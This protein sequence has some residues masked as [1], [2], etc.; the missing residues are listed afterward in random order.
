LTQYFLIPALL[1]PWPTTSTGLPKTVATTGGS[2]VIDELVSLS[3]FNPLQDHSFQFF[4]LLL[5][6]S[7]RFHRIL[8]FVIVETTGLVEDRYYSKTRYEKYHHRD[9]STSERRHPY[10]G[11]DYRSSEHRTH[12]GHV[13][14]SHVSSE[15]SQLHIN[16]VRFMSLI[17]VIT[18]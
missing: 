3:P 13:S 12:R 5:N 2:I 7:T 9:R 6:P 18:K 1:P 8:T 17:R 4:F 10:S 15:T 16:R 11:E 14:S